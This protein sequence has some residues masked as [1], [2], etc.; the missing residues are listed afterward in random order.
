MARYKTRASIRRQQN[1]KPTSERATYRSSR[2][3][4]G[5]P[6][7]SF[8]APPRPPR[9]IQRRAVLSCESDSTNNDEASEITAA[10][11]L[12][13]VVALGAGSRHLDVDLASIDHLFVHRR[14]RFVGRLLVLPARHILEPEQNRSNKKKKNPMPTRTTKSTLVLSQQSFSILTS[15][16]SRSRANEYR[17]Q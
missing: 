5:S 12:G 16:Q 1:T 11:R 4:R 17:E 13:H 6:S 7:P 3:T 8:L 15:Q 14:N 10:A 2:G 9:P